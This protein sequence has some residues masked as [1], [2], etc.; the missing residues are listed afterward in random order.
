ML[1]PSNVRELALAIA[2]GADEAALT[3]HGTELASIAADL[4]LSSGDVS[5]LAGYARDYKKTPPTQE[6][7]EAN[8]RK[9]SVELRAQYGKD[10]DRVMADA[11][12]VVKR[13]HRLEQLLEVSALG[14]H[15]EVI[16]LMVD[17]GRRARSRG[18][19]R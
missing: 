19:L 10:I 8:H 6:Q 15:A 3:R 9:V 13:D 16:K 14:D 1:G 12:A 5:K 17:A 4:G 2:P 18:Q 11:R 7:R